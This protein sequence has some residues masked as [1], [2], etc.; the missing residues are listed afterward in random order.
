MARKT[1]AVRIVELEKELVM[2]QGLLE[3]T[4]KRNREL[5]NAE[6]GTFLHSPTYIQMK[7]QI[8]FLEKL[9]ALDKN[10]MDSVIKQS[11]KTDAAI[12]QI[13]EDNK[14]LTE[15]HTDIE[16][17]IGITENWHSASEFKKLEEKILELEATIEQKTLAIENRDAEVYRLQMRLAEEIIDKK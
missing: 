15:G 10:H 16:Y 9:G 1:K 7:E 13:Y 5:V 2:Y 17:F 6:E 12:R 11:K 3:K 8:N 4:Q 14:R